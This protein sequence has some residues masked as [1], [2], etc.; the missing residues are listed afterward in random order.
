MRY[1][2]EAA[3]VVGMLVGFM[4]T[5]LGLGLVSTSGGGAWVMAGI[6]AAIFWLSFSRLRALLRTK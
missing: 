1:L 4:V 3:L 2:A 6:G 5:W